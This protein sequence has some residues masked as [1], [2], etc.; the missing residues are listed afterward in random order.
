M[1]KRCTLATQGIAYSLV[2]SPHAPKLIRHDGNGQTDSRPIK[3]TDWAVFHLQA[4]ELH[5]TYLQDFPRLGLA[6]ISLPS[7][8]KDAQPLARATRYVV[9]I[10]KDIDTPGTTKGI[11]EDPERCSKEERDKVKLKVAK[12]LESTAILEESVG[13]RHQQAATLSE[14]QLRHERLSAF[15]RAPRWRTPPSRPAT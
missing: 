4:L 6:H 12:A 9:R 11:A 3:A 15:S 5:V 1:A 14:P 8:A 2:P 13:L 10:T 7:Q